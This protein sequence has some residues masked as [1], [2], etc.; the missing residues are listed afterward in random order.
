MGHMSRDLELR[1][2]VL[3]DRMYHPLKILQGRHILQITWA[4]PRALV[5]ARMHQYV[6]GYRTFFENLCST[7]FSSLVSIMRSSC[8]VSMLP[9][10]SP[11]VSLLQQSCASAT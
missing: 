3:D 7:S 2:G 1:R 5:R 11:A 9:S 6:P 4:D 8:K 10:N